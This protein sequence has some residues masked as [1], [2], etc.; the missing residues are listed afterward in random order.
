VLV[1]QVHPVGPSHTDAIARCAEQQY[2][3]S[4]LFYEVLPPQTATATPQ[5]PNGFGPH[6][7]TDGEEMRSSSSSASSAVPNG[8]M[9]A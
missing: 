6:A 9:R 7:H 3:P 1:V 5:Q 8:G 4:L 2:Q